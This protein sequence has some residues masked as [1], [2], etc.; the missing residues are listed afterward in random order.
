MEVWFGELDGS[1]PGDGE[2]GTGVV[3][4]VEDAAVA[5][6][7]GRGGCVEKQRPEKH[8]FADLGEASG[9]AMLGEEVRNGGGF[10]NAAAVGAGRDAEGAVVVAAVVEVESSGEE[11]F[12]RAK[13]R[14]GVVDAV[15]LAGEGE[16]AG[17]G[18]SGEGEHEVL[19]PG[20]FPVGGWGFVEGDRLDGA[21]VGWKESEGDESLADGYGCCGYFRVVEQA[22]LSG[23]SGAEGRLSDRVE[24]GGRE[25]GTDG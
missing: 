20:Y 16:A 2:G 23:G 13:R 6:S 8:A 24:Q 1:V 3:D 12:E 15:F 21:A 22:A 10:D 9:F 14:A 25:V 5:W 4:D 7:G 19:V 17:D 11:V 18:S